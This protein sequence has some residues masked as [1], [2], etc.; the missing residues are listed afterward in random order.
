MGHDKRKDA[1]YRKRLTLKFGTGDDVSRVGFTEDIS[2]TGI[3]I[4]STAP[5]AP[6]TILTVEITT[7]KEEKILLRG[8]IMWAKKV[9]Q[10]MMHRIKGGMG[11]LITEFI[12]NEEIYRLLCEYRRN[13]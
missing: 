4:R 11:L 3:F 8:R 5:V 13:L 7:L 12:E 6:N 1:R 2:E 9:P 10:N